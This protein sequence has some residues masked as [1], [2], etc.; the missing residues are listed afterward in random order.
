[1]LDKK[2]FESR[3]R[4]I[5][6]FDGLVP[7]NGAQ[8]HIK[9]LSEQ[10]S[11]CL[12]SLEAAQADVVK[13]FSLGEVN[14]EKMERHE[15]Y[16]L[17]INAY[18]TGIATVLG[19]ALLSLGFLGTGYLLGGSNMEAWSSS[20]MLI[21]AG[22]G[23]LPGVPV[24]IVNYLSNRKHFNRQ[25]VEKKKFNF[26][27]KRIMKRV[28]N[29]EY[30]NALFAMQIDTNMSQI[31]GGKFSLKEK[32]TVTKTNRKGIVTTKEVEVYK[33]EYQHLSFWTKRKLNKVINAFNEQYAALNSIQVELESRVDEIKKQNKKTRAEAAA[34]AKKVTTQVAPATPEEKPTQKSKPKQTPKAAPQQ[35]VDEKPTITDVAPPQ[36]STV[37][38]EDVVDDALEGQISIFDTISFEEA[39]PQRP[40]KKTTTKSKTTSTSTSTGTGGKR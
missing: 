12:T 28:K 33:E 2:F 11:E 25:E 36:V 16:P 40:K 29:K 14:R 23:A 15:K 6:Q 21:G 31:L 3:R 38:N 17:A 30:A 27:E 10:Y 24:A 7:K 39:K 19:S 35:V 18:H 4:F 1:M 9:K 8:T 13:L 26:I 22:V 32:K 34:Q 5:A 20:L 37:P